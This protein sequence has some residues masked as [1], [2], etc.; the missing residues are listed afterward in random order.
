MKNKLLI[1]Y[2]LISISLNVNADYL[3]KGVIMCNNPDSIRKLVSFDDNG[4]SMKFMNYFSSMQNI[5]ICSQTIMAMTPS[6]LG[7]TDLSGGVT[8]IGTQIF[9]ITSDIK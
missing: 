7:R 4:D 8:Q 2:I 6:N 1:I 5:G 3:K 9:V